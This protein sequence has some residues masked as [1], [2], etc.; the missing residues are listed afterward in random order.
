MSSTDNARF[1]CWRRVANIA[2]RYDPPAI[3]LVD[4]LVDQ[5]CFM[6][7]SRSINRLAVLDWSALIFGVPML[8]AGIA[9]GLW[10]LY[11]V[12]TYERAEGTARY[13]GIAETSPGKHRGGSKFVIS[14]QGPQRSHSFEVVTL[15]WLGLRYDDGE[16]VP[17]MYPASDPD[18]GFR[19]TFVNLWLLP[20]L[21]IPSGLLIAWGGW[22][23]G[24]R[25]DEADEADLTA[26][27]L[28]DRGRR[29]PKRRRSDVD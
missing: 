17:V 23:R 8:F 14:Y 21:L 18:R 12:A 5:G 15:G 6:V 26:E 24:R 13:L 20:L 29:W 16:K 4:S 3:L 10:S 11:C 9:L 22:K 27:E 25:K 1:V 19:R 2:G 28:V 7:K